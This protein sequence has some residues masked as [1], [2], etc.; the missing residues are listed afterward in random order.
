MR[1]SIGHSH[2]DGIDAAARARSINRMHPQLMRARHSRNVA[3]VT[4]MQQSNIASGYY[5]R[6]REVTQLLCRRLI[7]SSAIVFW[8][9]L[10]TA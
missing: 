9:S 10:L 4:K 2:S 6:A 3:D 8:L 7:L 5:I 1:V